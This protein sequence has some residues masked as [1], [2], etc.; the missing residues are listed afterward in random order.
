MIC[1]HPR[2]IVKV[3]QTQTNP[4]QTTNQQGF[5]QQGSNSV[6]QNN[7]GLKVNK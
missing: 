5:Q 1:G 2:K 7:A 6:N 3:D 4:Q